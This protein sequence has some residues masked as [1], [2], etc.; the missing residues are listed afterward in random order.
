MYF[1]GFSGATTFLPEA[2]PES[3]YA[4]PTVITDFRLLGNSHSPTLKT[5]PQAISYASEII[6]SHKQTPFS[7]T[8]A[9]FAYSN[10][11]TN[12]YR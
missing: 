11:P 12:R 1:A 3:N 9:A 8:F 7:L 2:I 5:T 4:P 6:L 10:A